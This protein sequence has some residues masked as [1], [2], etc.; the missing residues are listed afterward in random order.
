[1][2]KWMLSLF[3]MSLIVACNDSNDARQSDDLDRRADSL[4]VVPRDSSVMS[5]PD[6]STR[7]DPSFPR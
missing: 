5:Y 1:M 2:K 7:P 6:D 3:V 4:H